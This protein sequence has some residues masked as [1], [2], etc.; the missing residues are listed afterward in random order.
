ML[1][2]F[3][4]NEIRTNGIHIGLMIALNISYFRH[5]HRN[6]KSKIQSGTHSAVPAE[7][8]LNDDLNQDWWTKYYNSYE[9]LIKETKIEKLL[10]SEQKC[11]L[12]KNA[13]NSPNFE[14]NSFLKGARV[15]QRL[16]SK[17][18]RKNAQHNVI[19]SPKNLAKN[20]QSSSGLC[21][22]RNNN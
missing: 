18:W 15:V 17:S 5:L 10:K 8:G 7:D 6:S 22:V 19:S 4:L 3:I 1:T 20:I 11:A 21:Q 12:S 2:Q 9:R 16:T 13:L 14:K